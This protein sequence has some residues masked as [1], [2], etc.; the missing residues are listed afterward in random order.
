MDREDGELG[1]EEGEP[2]DERQAGA[3]GGQDAA[4]AEGGGQGPHRRHHPVCRGEGE[5]V[6]GPP[7]GSI[8]L[9]VS[10]SGLMSRSCSNTTSYSVEL[11]MKAPIAFIW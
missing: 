2:G 10:W 4:V 9:M 7:G 1:V 8:A 6:E 3:G 5:G 11:A